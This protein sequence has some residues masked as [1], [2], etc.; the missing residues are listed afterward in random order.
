MKIITTYKLATTITLTF[1]ALLFPALA[2]AGCGSFDPRLAMH[3]GPAVAAPQDQSAAESSSWNPQD[4]REWT[5]PG[6][7]HRLA[8]QRRTYVNSKML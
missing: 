1:G 8:N 4:P 6:G 7:W 2:S 5:L 3:P